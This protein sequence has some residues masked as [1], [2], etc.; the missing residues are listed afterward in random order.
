M[1][2]PD[3]KALL[4]D[5]NALYGV[6]VPFGRRG[7][8]NGAAPAVLRWS[9]GTEREGAE[10]SGEPSSR[11]RALRIAV[12]EMSIDAGAPLA[13]PPDILV[14]RVL[15]LP[16]ADDES[17]DSMVR[18]KM[19]RLA[20]VADDD[21]E[22]D[23]EIVGATE[24]TTRVFAV[25]VPTATLTKVADDLAASGLAV[26]RLDSSLLCEWR[27]WATARGLPEEDASLAVVF[28]L[29]SGRFDLVVADA[30]GPA[31]ARTLGTPATPEDFAREVTLSFL[32][33]SAD[34]SAPFPT[35]FAL[36]AREGLDP[37]YAEALAGV[38]GAPPEVVPEGDLPAYVV[39]A[40]EREEQG[41]CIDI[42]PDAWRAEERAAVTRRRF[43]A[44][45]ATAVALW[46]LILAGLIVAPRLVKQ[47]TAAVDREIAALR[48]AYAAVADTRSR[49][50]LIRSYE[51]RSH[52]LLD[53]LR[54]VCTVMP[55]GVTFSSL[56]YEKGGESV[57]NGKPLPGGIK[58][59]GD[60]EQSAAI[61]AF[62]NALDG[63]GPFVPAKLTGPTMD[64]SRRR[65]KFELD[66]RFA[67]EAQP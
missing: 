28:A 6:A 4:I 3:L 44:G 25:A 31:F 49:V 60:A 15:S 39:S 45:I 5:D 64:G 32:D 46:A 10:D 2:E 40:A 65:Y 62:K 66:S 18:L 12:E 58:V 36:V 22:V 67:E 55:E 35:A 21:L 34:G 61:L 52:S 54:D 7:A 56:T 43:I 16:A 30:H 17:L 57:Q 20:P 53:I 59:A 9:I 63:M 42:V 51:D 23:F 8:D 19:E 50:R 33:L 47:K 24:T 1:P 41:D 48:P 27:S 37:A 14:T 13:L 26:T 38:A 11:A 29:P